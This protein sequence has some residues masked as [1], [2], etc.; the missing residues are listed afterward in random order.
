LARSLANRG[1]LYILGTGGAM[2]LIDSTDKRDCR[3]C[4]TDLP[5]EVLVERRNPGVS[6]FALLAISILRPARSRSIRVDRNGHFS[7]KLLASALLGPAKPDFEPLTHGLA[8]MPPHGACRLVHPR[9]TITR[10]PHPGRLFGG[11][12][13]EKIFSLDRSARCQGCSRSAP[14]MVACARSCSPALRGVEPGDRAGADIAD[15]MTRLTARRG[16]HGQ[17]TA[18]HPA[19]GRAQ[20]RGLARGCRR[21]Q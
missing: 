1:S 8:P 21:P 5:V 2:D 18:A 17:R 12:C 19:W 9:L 10:R 20:G 7:P 3:R 14:I 6:D 4:A 13:V 15:G 16:Q 11:V